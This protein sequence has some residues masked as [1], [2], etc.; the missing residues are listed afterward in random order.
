ME[1][2]K[3]NH[4]S[5]FMPKRTKMALPVPTKSFLHRQA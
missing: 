4:L 1:S 5:L 3:V 2:Y